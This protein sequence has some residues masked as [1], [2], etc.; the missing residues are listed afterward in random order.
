MPTDGHQE[1]DTLSYLPAK[2]KS[3]RGF[4]K[5]NRSST[6]FVPG[7]LHIFYRF[8][9]QCF[10]TFLQSANDK[11]RC[12]GLLEQAFFHHFTAV[13]WGRG[14]ELRSISGKAPLTSLFCYR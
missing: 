8:N 4:L 2:C 9:D 1:C 6:H 3:Y 10:Q 11:W 13:L 12:S 5:N 14:F 7:D